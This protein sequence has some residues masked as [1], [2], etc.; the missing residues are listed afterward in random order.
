MNVK[1]FFKKIAEYVFPKGITCNGCNKELST[2]NEFSLCQQ[3]YSELKLLNNSLEYENIEVFSCYEYVDVVKK[4]ILAYKD[5][6]RPYLSEY[7]AK[8]MSNLYE[9]QI[10]FC[11]VFCFVP[12]CEKTIRK[13]GY[14]AMKNVAKFFAE[15]TDISLMQEIKRIKHS[16]DQTMLNISQRKQFVLDNFWV[17][18]GF[19]RGKTVL[20]LDDLVTSGATLNE[21]A[22]VLSAVGGAKKV[23]ALTYARAV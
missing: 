12:S 21:C 2:D 1:S 9:E 20:I 19:Y 18:E 5:G 14:D 8:A 4:T 11:D 10:K 22:R 17:K 6:N 13:R 3:C 23:V 15:N 16:T 7:M